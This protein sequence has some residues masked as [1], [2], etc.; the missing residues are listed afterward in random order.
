MTCEECGG[1]GFVT[2][3][4]WPDRGEP[5]EPERCPVCGRNDDDEEDVTSPEFWRKRVDERLKRLER[6]DTLIIMSVPEG[7]KNDG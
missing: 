7:R 1:R 3:Q 4:A 5:T 6:C 2:G